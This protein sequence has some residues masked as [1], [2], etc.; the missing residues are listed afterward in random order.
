MSER[1]LWYGTSGPHDAKIVIVGESWGAEEAARKQPFIGSSGQELNRMLSHAGISRGDVLCTN[2]VAEKPDGNETWRFFHPKASMA[3]Q[4]KVGG[5]LPSST[6]IAEVGRLYNQLAYRPRSLVIAAGNFSLWACS[7]VTGAETI[8]ESNGRKVPTELQTYGPTGITLWRGSMLYCEPRGK[9]WIANAPE[10]P[11]TP[12]LP[13]IHPAAILRQWSWR[14]TTI[15]DL[16]KRV[17]QALRGDWRPNAERMLAPPSFD[18][19]I[20]QLISYVRAGGY[21]AADIETFRRKFITCIGFAND[22]HSAI[23]I[24]FIS[25]VNRDGS[26]NSYWTPQQEAQIVAL[27]RQVLTHP[28]IRII[29]QNFIYDTQ[30]IQHWFGVTPRLHH[31]TMLAQNVLFPGTPKDLAHLSSL[32]CHYHWYWKD[33]V[34]DRSRLG[35]L[36]QLLEYN[37]IDAMRTFEIAQNQM[38]YIKLHG[39]EE[40][41]RFKMATNRLCLRMMNRGVLY[42]DAKR[43]PMLS[44]LMDV[45]AAFQNELLGIIPQSMVK[46]HKLKRDGSPA[47]GQTYWYNSPQQTAELLYDILGMDEVRNRK[48]GART[49]GKEALP[50]LERKYPEFTALFRRLDYLGSL[51][52]T[53]QVINMKTEH[54]GRVR[55]SY[56]PGG[57]ETHRLSSSENVF[58]R[59]TNLQNLSKGEEDD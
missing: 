1:D 22:P 43:G 13:I 25:G 56:N 55:C 49:V 40:Q 58:G 33:D 35:D 37:C 57:T 39:Q 27:L 20:G 17:P 30:Y 18:E 52:N 4:P 42:D 15:Q 59:G 3:L 34:K 9:H 19:A 48:T 28:G 26:L 38:A 44:D 5:L 14:D 53:I 2:V 21:L 47:N 16:K 11:K 23:S 45:Q 50:V 6:V 8:R 46:P 29:G 54:D 51:D 32:Y 36:G 31:D 41:M 24:P 10:L 12:L 7:N